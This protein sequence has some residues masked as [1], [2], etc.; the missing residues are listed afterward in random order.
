MSTP[1]GIGWQRYR[2]YKIKVC[3]KDLIPFNK[4]EPVIQQIRVNTAQVAK[5]SLSLLINSFSCLL[6]NL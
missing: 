2:G 4:T 6:V 3:Y 5:L 1:D